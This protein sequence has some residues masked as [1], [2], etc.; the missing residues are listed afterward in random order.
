[1]EN[2]VD[3]LVIGAGVSGIGAAARLGMECP[4]RTYAVLEA[5]DAIGGTW[6]LFRYPGVRSDSDIFTFSYP[7]K[8]WTGEASLADGADIRA[9]IEETAREFGVL[10]RVRFGTRVVR[11]SWSSETA[12]WTVDTLTGPEGRPETWTC[13]FLFSCTGYYDHD[14]GF[15]PEFAG[16]E[17]FGGTVVHPQLWPEDLDYTGKRVVVIGSG[18]TAMTL[19]PSMAGTAGHV[20]MLQ[21]S[22]TYVTSLPRHDAVADLLRKVLPAGAAHKAIR[23]KN[24]AVTLGFYE[25]CRR[26][27]SAARKVLLGRISTHMGRE[28][29]DEHF[30]PRYDPWDQRLCVIPDAD[31]MKAIKAGDASVVTDRIERFEEGGVRLA[32]GELLEADIVVTATG[33]QLKALGGLDL[34][35]DGEQLELADQM[36]YRGLM[37]AGVPNLAISIG[38]INASWTLRSDLICQYVCRYLNHLSTHDLAY[39]AP[40]PDPSQE[41]RPILDLASGYVQRSLSAFPSAGAT[42][43]WTVRQNYV[44]DSRELAGADVTEA[45]RFVSR[46]E[47]LQP[48]V[49]RESIE[50]S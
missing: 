20:T 11:A 26:F 24:I 31:L 41:R 49:A 16:L 10:D 19:V 33:L 8:P 44:L 46:S 17:D 18:A 36:A 37:L 12:R 1:M 6:D 47:V 34:H 23:A 13:S 25:F 21:R 35:V 48:A 27:P 15:T 4:D 7:F 9:Y 28:F 2:Y 38:Y 39:G 3:V 45:M 40:V 43:P 14:G 30:T 32:S 29:T 22:P 42:A 5:R 50:A